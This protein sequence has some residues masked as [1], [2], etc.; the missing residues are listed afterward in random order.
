MPARLNI[1][2]FGSSEK[3]KSQIVSRRNL[4]QVR[5]PDKSSTGVTVHVVG[6]NSWHKRS[7]RDSMARNKTKIKNKKITLRKNLPNKMRILVFV[8]HSVFD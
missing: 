5:T 2:S 3:D 7:Q 6:L 1:W 4:H 8:L